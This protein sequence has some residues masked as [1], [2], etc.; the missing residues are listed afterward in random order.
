MKTLVQEFI[1]K[2]YRREFDDFPD[3]DGKVAV[4]AIKQ[5]DMTEFVKRINA[6]E[7][8]RDSLK[9]QLATKL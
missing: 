9:K 4:T 3:E 8:E 7:D 5:R 6:L 1:P 2:M